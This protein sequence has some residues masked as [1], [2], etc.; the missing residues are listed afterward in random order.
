MIAIKYA[1]L[2]L[3]GV[4]GLVISTFGPVKI[5]FAEALA[6]SYYR[7]ALGALLIVLLLISVAVGLFILT[8]DAN[9]FKS[10]IVQFVKSR[11]QRDLLIEGSIKVS[12]FPKLGLD[13]GRVSLS[14]RNSAREFA[15]ISNARLYIAWL[16]LFKRQLVFDRVE[17]SGINANVIRLKD[18]STNFDDLLIRDEHLAPLSFDIDSV[19]I[20]DSSINWQDEME[21]QRVTLQNL[22]IET[23]RLA[24]TLPSDLTASFR[25]NSETLHLNSSVKLASRLF[26][27]RKAGRYEF[28]N[29]EG[30]LEGDVAYVSGLVVKFAG[31][32]DSYPTK[33][34]FTAE[35]FLVTATGK[36]GRHLLDAKL[37][38]PKLQLDSGKLVGSQFSLESTASYRDE[39]L[40][41]SLQLPLYEF[42]DKVFKAPEMVADFD[43][44]SN[45]RAL[46]G[47]LL[48]PLA[49]SFESAAKLQL[50]TIS[51]HIAGKHPILS[52]GADANATGNLQADFIEQ[53]VNLDFIAKFDD[54]QVSGN[55][56][57]KG[58]T[59][60]TYTFDIHADHLDLDRHIATDWIKQFRDDA[61]PLDLTALQDLTVQ[62]KLRAGD[63]KIAGI[64]ARKLS[65]AIKIEQSALTIAP[66]SAKLYGGTLT[67]SITVDVQDTAQIAVK[68]SLSGFQMATLLADTANAGKFSGKASLGF[69]LSTAGNSVVAL[70]KALS[71]RVSLDVSRGMLAGIDLRAA[72]LKGK[73]DL[74]RQADKHVYAAK[75]SDMTEFSDL[76]TTFNFK[77]GVALD[78]LFEMKS[79]MIRT[80]GNGDIDFDSSSINYHLNATVS[81]VLKR[82][83]AG[84][85]AEIKGVTVPIRVF[86]PYSAPSI[87]LD[88]GSASG[89]NIAQLAAARTAREAAATVTPPKRTT[90]PKARVAKQAKKQPL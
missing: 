46:Q 41:A 16:P 79:P 15:S 49:I 56:A 54:G 11:T 26:F 76:K 78:S 51:L 24:D 64:R 45:R 50:D 48:T 82:R 74:G 37:G 14:Q 29:I 55:M 75:F 58:F 63:I 87:G 38:V 19:R 4:V 53:S 85:L 39:I 17:I 65:A 44:K 35:N 31:S 40:T 18:G 57:V 88:F 28:A 68:Q 70:R 2:G 84:A 25:L 33:K 71:G 47:R 8:F 43:F 20:T 32:L 13:S 1:L 7:Y 30:N 21:S 77:D 81:P 66:L 83:S 10:E 72:L 59:K 12:F 5:P 34:S 80:A 61:T 42:V 3:A 67:S 62:G 60:P 90:K 73:G 9:N 22:Q 36:S 27:D 86:G 6:K 89:G 23:G 69:D 52:G